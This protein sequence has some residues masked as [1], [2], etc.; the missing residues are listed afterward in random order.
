MIIGRW[1]KSVWLTY[2]GVA[3][4]CVGV[5]LAITT[6]NFKF[7]CICLIAAGI[8]DM[9]DGFVA[10]CNKGR[11]KEAK[12]FG[13]ELD[14]VADV[15]NFIALP[16]AIVCSMGMKEP[17]EIIPVIIF[18]VCGIARLAYFNTLALRTDDP[19]TYYHGL[20]VTYT[21]L[22][23][24]VCF[25]A[26]SLL[27]PTISR[28]LLLIVILIIGILNILDIHIPKPKPKDYWIFIALAIIV[29]VLLG[30]II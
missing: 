12:Q 18:S 10:R 26:F 19:V 2:L 20:P 4:S 24:P 21:A 1:D 28:E 14:S 7:S 11:D 3:L 25:S 23:V 17:Y 22:I 29:S 30:A 13:V 27:A 6:H 15:I 9:L 8:C 16:I 5:F